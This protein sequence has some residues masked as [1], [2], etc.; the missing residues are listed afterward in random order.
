MG[1]NG[2]KTPMTARR[3]AIVA[4]GLCIATGPAL[5]DDSL[6]DSVE[7]FLQQTQDKIA[8]SKLW[9]FEVRPSLHESVIW[10]DNIY[11][12]AKDEDNVILT[13]VTGNGVDI[14]NPAQLA[15]IEQT[16]PDFRDTS[17]QGR[18]SDFIIQSDLNVDIVLPVNDSYTKA[19][20]N[21]KSMEILGVEVKNQEYLDHNELDNNSVFLHTNLFGFIS[22][23]FN[24]EAGNNFWIHVK[25]DFSKLKDPLDTSIRLLRQD[26]LTSL[27]SF[28]DFERTENTA[29]IDVGWNGGNVDASAGYENYHLLLDAEE[30]DQ[31]E[32]TRHNFHAELGTGLQQSR[33]YLRYDYWIYHFARAPLHDA[34]GNTVGHAQILND[35]NVHMGTLGFTGPLFSDRMT[36]KLEGS[37]ENWEPDDDGLSQD[38]EHFAGFIGHAQLAYRPWE[39]RNT[40]F[41][42]EYQHRLTY[43]AISNYNST[44]EGTFT[45]LHEIIPKRLDADFNL[46][47][48]T[49]TPTDGPVRKLLETGVGLTYHV[50]KQ[51]D[52]SARYVF[53][54]QTAQKEITTSSAFARGTGGNTRLYQYEI[55]SNSEFYQNIV[56]LGFVLHF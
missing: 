9:K 36:T 48:S 15:R 47:F 51:L 3:A 17:T 37:Y 12:N 43:S 5:A 14:K 20:G 40:Q 18:Q 49:T 19:F 27:R 1:E 35:A 44:H 6:S 45:V 46:S 39:E 2:M 22:D 4:A 50:Y 54:H 26:G 42:F 21:K 31:V 55:K 29:N 34:R 25:D 10:T 7:K 56:E 33:G 23:L 16:L 11:L 32:H 24:V 8:D 38:S 52:V 53:R 30:L 13:R 28:N 41:Q